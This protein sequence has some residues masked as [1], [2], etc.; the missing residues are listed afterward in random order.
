MYYY[1]Y[2]YYFVQERRQNA[3]LFN[4]FSFFVNA[5]EQLMSG[6]NVDLDAVEL[7]RQRAQLLLVSVEH[8]QRAAR[9]HLQP[10]QFL[11]PLIYL[12]NVLL[13]LNLQL[14]EV[15]LMKHLSHLLFLQRVSIKFNIS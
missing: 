4:N 13:I 1:Y 3:N 6:V 2:Y 8:L 7:H 11:V 5:S 10:Q 15:H 9:H 12:L 14:T